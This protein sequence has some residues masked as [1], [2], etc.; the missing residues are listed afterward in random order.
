MKKVQA[1]YDEVAAIYDRRYSTGK[2]SQ[3]Y[4]RLARQV[5]ECLESDGLLLDIGCGTG[6]FLSRYLSLG[7]EA[8]G[9]DLSRGMI[10]R[11]RRRLPESEFLVGT[12][13]ALPFRENS[14]DAVAS[15]LT[16]S[17]IQ[18]PE[19]MVADVYR[20]LRPGG[21]FA[22]CTLG[23]NVLTSV[24]PALYWLGEKMELR[25]IGVGDFDERY[26]TEVEMEDLLEQA[27][28]CRVS[29]RRCSFAHASLASPIFHIA[30]KMEPFVEE[31]LP[32]LAYNLCA[33][34]T[35]PA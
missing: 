30:R 32:Y 17:Y 14:F 35:K 31:K 1:H 25:K 4:A 24:V 21:R 2:G 3:Y 10:A 19:E 9:I 33:S 18:H 5:L 6:L 29:V 20:I 28:F 12:A 7:N 11:A 13:D 22:L 34:G 27:G 16:F 26:Y 15:L 8:V 23:K